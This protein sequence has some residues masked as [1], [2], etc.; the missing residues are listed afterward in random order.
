M[1]RL[2]EVWCMT[3]VSSRNPGDF[4]ISTL[5]SRP[6]DQV[7]QPVVS[8]ESSVNFGV[9]Y[10]ANLI[11]MFPIDHYCWWGW[12]LVLARKRVWYCQF[13]LGDVEHRVDSME[14]GRES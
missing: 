7:V 14:L 9:E 4:L 12:G 2:G 6:F 13:E 1:E 11:F 5:V 8:L 10:L 3:Q